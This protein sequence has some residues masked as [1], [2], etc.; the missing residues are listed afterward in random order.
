MTTTNTTPKTY[1]VD[2][3]FPGLTLQEL[4][5]QVHP[6][7]ARRLLNDEEYAEFLKL[8]AAH[9]ELTAAQAREYAETHYF[10]GCYGD[11]LTDC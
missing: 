2:P 7:C 1:I 5:E 10:P 8:Q 3:D 9:F 11:A 4:A 6:Q